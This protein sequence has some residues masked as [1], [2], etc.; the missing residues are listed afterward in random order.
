MAWRIG[1]VALAA[2]AL[3]ASRTAAAGFE[4]GLEAGASPVLD[5]GSVLV[6]L[7]VCPAFAA[8]G[9]A[10]ELCFGFD[11]GRLVEERGAVEA[12]IR[13]SLL[14]VALG[15]RFGV[16]LERIVP[17]VA[18]HVGPLFH[19]TTTTVMGAP[20]ADYQTHLV[21]DVGALVVGHFL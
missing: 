16:E 9:W 5:G 12:S 11:H 15:G 18:A 19:W 3:L 14:E 10:A 7:E 8:G 13:M 6:G 2:L 20:V 4:V 1:T 21:L 17:Y